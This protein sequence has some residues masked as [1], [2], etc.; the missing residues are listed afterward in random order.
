MFS[1]CQALIL[2]ILLLFNK[3]YFSTYSEPDSFLCSQQ[4]LT[5]LIPTTLG[6]VILSPFYRLGNQGT[7]VNSLSMSHREEAA[8]SELEL[9]KS[10]HRATAVNYCTSLFFQ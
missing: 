7:Q 10:E 2:S 4:I 5:H 9:R 1:V 8:K 6:S 3:H